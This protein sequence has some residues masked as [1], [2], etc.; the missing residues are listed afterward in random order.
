MDSREHG[1]I[2]CLLI[3]CAFVMSACDCD[4]SDV[5]ATD[6]DST[7]DHFLDDDS[8]DNDVVDDD[9]D[10]C[11]HCSLP[12]DCSVIFGPDWICLDGCCVPVEDDDTLDD[13]LA[14]D[15]SVDD[16]AA[17]DDAT[18]DDIADDDATDDDTADDDAADDDIADDDAADDDTTVCDGCLIDEYC[19]QDGEI[20]PDNVC[21]YCNS[22]ELNNAWSSNDGAACDDETSCNGADT[23]QHGSCSVHAEPSCDPLLQYCDEVNVVCVS[24]GYVFAPSGTFNM[25]SPEGETGRQDDELLHEVTLTNNFE[26]G[27]TEVTQSQF[28]DVIGWNPSYY[29]PNGAGDDCGDDCPVEYVSWFD[30]LVYANELSIEFGYDPCFLLSDV[31]CEDG[32]EVENS[33]MSCMNE[34]KGGVDSA[35]VAPNGVDSVYQCEGFRLPTEAEWEYAARAGTTTPFYNGEITYTECAL[36]PNLKL[37][38]WYCGNSSAVTHPTAL[39]AS[40]EWGLYDTSG[41]VWEWNW[42]WYVDE[43]SGSATNPE[44]AVNGTDRVFRGGYINGLARVCRSANRFWA[45]PD[46]RFTPAGFR[47]VRTLAE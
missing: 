23:C 14:D 40:N 30:V 43:Y 10:E 25:G 38:G 18:D 36:D 41:N 35:T 34:A 21:E 16:D 26:I 42:D 11:T 47:V 20:N 19:Y 1:W 6:D 27:A 39:L 7:D 2:I 8:A 31:V 17:D 5:T 32:T 37:I 44:G 45:P 29:G 28:E 46:R 4:D 33:Y 13:D 3:A 9:Q 24:N 12:A 22:A 15:D